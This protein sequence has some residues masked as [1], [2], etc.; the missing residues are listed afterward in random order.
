MSKLAT[1]DTAAVAVQEM[2]RA[3]DRVR[4]LL[5]LPVPPVHDLEAAI[6]D[7]SVWTDAVHQILMSAHLGT[8]QEIGD[9]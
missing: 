6:R 1:L 7:A 4:A 2:R 8:S 9:S 3:T 5:A